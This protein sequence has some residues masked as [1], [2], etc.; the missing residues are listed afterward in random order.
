MVKNPTAEKA[1]LKKV[2]EYMEATNKRLEKLEKE[3]NMSLHY[4]RRDT[5]EI[6]GIPADISNHNLEEEVAKIYEKAGKVNGYKLD[7]SN[8]QAWH[9]D[10]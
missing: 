7:A 2:Q 4:V 3:Q 6:T 8:M 9:N 1:L 10:L 5:I